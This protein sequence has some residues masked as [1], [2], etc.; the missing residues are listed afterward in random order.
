MCAIIENVYFQNIVSGVIGGVVVLLFQLGFEYLK[1]KRENREKLKIGNSDLLILDKY[2][3]YKYEPHKYSIE[4]II[5]EFG[6][7][8][9]KEK[10]NFD[11]IDVETFQYNF[12]NAKVI[13]SKKI[14]SSEIISTTLFSIEDRN[15]PVL[16]RL[17]FEDEELEM[18]KAII[19]DT[20]IRDGINLENFP[21]PF[22]TNSIVQTLYFYR[23]IKH[24]TF[25]YQIEG[26]YDSIEETKGQKI[27]QVCI[28]QLSNVTPMLSN[29]DIF[30]S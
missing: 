5:S 26:S 25:S 30:Y 19:N 17:S 10:E 1:T 6:Q 21:T 4:K 16:C 23:Q 13:F 2:F 24:L 12:K 22:L 18:G 9:K 3:L 29:H 14:D 15:N 11:G 20:I 27:N 7:P 28:S 8:F